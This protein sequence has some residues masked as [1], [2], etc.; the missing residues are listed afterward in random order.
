[1]CQ[2]N[3]VSSIKADEKVEDIL[4]AYVVR[5]NILTGKRVDCF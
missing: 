3:Q 5:R 1:M 2:E 4:F